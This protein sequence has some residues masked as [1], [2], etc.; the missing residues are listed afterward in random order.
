MMYC[1]DTVDDEILHCNDC[2]GCMDMECKECQF[3]NAHFERC[4]MKNN[5]GEC[6]WKYSLNNNKKMR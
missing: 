3:R 2:K 4:V 6:A 1:V 5:S